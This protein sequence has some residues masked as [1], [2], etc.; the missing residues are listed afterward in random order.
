MHLM[1]IW[2]ANTIDDLHGKP[3]GTVRVRKGTVE[4]L[5][6]HLSAMA[7]SKHTA[8]YL[9]NWGTTTKTGPKKK[10][11]V[12]NS[13]VE[14]QYPEYV[15]YYYFAR[16]AVDDNNNN[17]QGSLSFEE[18]FNPKRWDLRQF[19]FIIALALANSMLAYNKFV[20]QTINQEPLSNAE[21]RR[22]LTREMIA[23]VEEQQTADDM[24]NRTVKRRKTSACEL[25][26]LEKHKGKWLHGGF[27]TTLDPYPKY[28]C[29]G[30]SCQRLIRT[31]CSCD[32]T[33][34]VCVQCWAEHLPS[35][36]N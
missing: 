24:Q 35:S 23:W 27:R 29:S 2:N 33:T 32:P 6:F 18:T 22:V 19:G 16:H 13:L 4:G 25:K 12:G 1:T 14:I 28:K 11:R 26:H 15:H 21:F 30:P 31:Y 5:N 36:P 20:R 7:D 17:R 10:R 3:V 8:I 34:I 9:T